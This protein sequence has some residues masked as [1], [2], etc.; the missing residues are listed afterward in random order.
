MTAED[1]SS[2]GVTVHVIKLD[3]LDHSSTYHFKITSVDVDGNVVSSDDYAFDTL[4]FPRVSGVKLE[5]QKNTATST[6]RAIWESNVPITSIVEYY[7]GGSNTAKEVSKSLL[8]T[9][10]SLLVSNL[11]DNTQYRF[12]IRGRDAY[13]NEATSEVLSYKTDFDTRAPEIYEITTETSIV[14]YG[15]D[16]KAQV[17]ISW[18]TDEVSTSQVEF[19]EGVTGESFSMNTQEDS[20]LTTSYVIVISDLKPSSSYYFRVKSKDASKN[21]GI[22]SVNSVLTEQAQSS[23]IDVIVKSFENTIGWVFNIFRR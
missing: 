18:F 7:E 22:S 16:A 13:G 12:V 1:R 19:N 4:T 10:H 23:I 14:G 9:K 6:V 8:E 15:T 21:E 11:K 20:S 3:N 5:Q 2:S 17:I